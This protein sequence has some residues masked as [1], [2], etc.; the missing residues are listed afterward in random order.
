MKSLYK[1]LFIFTVYSPDWRIFTN[2]LSYSQYCWRI[3][4]ISRRVNELITSNEIHLSAKDQLTL[5]V[6]IPL[7]DGSYRQREVG[8][9]QCRKQ[10]RGDR[11]EP[12]EELWIILWLIPVS[13]PTLWR[14]HR[15]GVGVQRSRG[16]P[17]RRR[18]DGLSGHCSFNQQWVYWMLL[19]GMLPMN[20]IH[21]DITMWRHSYFTCQ[22]SSSLKERRLSAQW[23]SQ[24]TQQLTSIIVAPFMENWRKQ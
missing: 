20:I 16:L 11:E 5:M 3:R 24:M 13:R 4:F 12:V 17:Q 18:R 6:T 1:M 10:S 15:R 8:K 22:L 9:R 2:S 21:F 19:H 7:D 14:M 23:Q